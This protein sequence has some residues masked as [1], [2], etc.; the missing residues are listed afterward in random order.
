MLGSFNA[1]GF[2]SESCRVIFVTLTDASEAVILEHYFLSCLHLC[3]VSI[4]VHDTYL[5]Y[6]SR[7]LHSKRKIPK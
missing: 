6:A 5:T 3:C 2:Y 7:S 1:V 4:T